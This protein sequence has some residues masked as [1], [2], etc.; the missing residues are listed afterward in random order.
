MVVALAIVRDLFSG[1]AAATVLSRLML[2]MGAAPIFA[3]TIGGAILV[4]GSWRWVFAALAI[5]G[6]LLLI[7]AVT[8]LKET[9]PPER[10]RQAELIP[11]LKTYGTLLRD[12]QFVVLAFV[13]AT[14]M[15]ALFAYIAG[16]SF[17]LQDGYGLNE[18]QFAIIFGI[19][20]IAI[21]GA[22]QLNVPLLSRYSPRQI[23][24]AGLTS[25]TAAGTIMLILA[26]TGI[27]GLI[28]FLIPLW[29]VLASVGFVLPNAPALALSRHGEAAGTAAALL[30]AAQFGLGAL[31]APVVGILGN[32][33]TAMALTMTT[34]SLIGLIALTAVMASARRKTTASDVRV[35]T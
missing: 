32:T 29:F 19:G 12:R 14:G 30:G 23:V 16:A 34:G 18:Q 10:R 4:A 27:G 28:G 9:L 22:S 15:S 3:P 31:V 35:Q 17:V 33:A 2:V 13:A 21:I 6:V 26:T 7:L 25:A 11:I 24:L 5:M 1:T 8:S 20:G